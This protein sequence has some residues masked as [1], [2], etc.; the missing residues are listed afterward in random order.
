MRIHKVLKSSNLSMGRRRGLEWVNELLLE[1]YLE[2]NGL[3]RFRHP[4][5]TTIPEMFQCRFIYFIC[6]SGVYLNVF[7]YG[8]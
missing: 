5:L 7:L 6:S 2:R 4:S 3:S 8:T 1:C